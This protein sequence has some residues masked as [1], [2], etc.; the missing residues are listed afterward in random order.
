MAS[1]ITQNKSQTLYNHLQDCYSKRTTAMT[2]PGSLLEMQNCRTPLHLW[3][4]M[5][6]FTRSPGDE[7]APGF[8]EAL[9]HKTL[10]DLSFS[11]CR[12]H[13][14][15][16]S[17][18]PTLLQS[19]WFPCHLSNIRETL[20]PH[21]SLGVECSPEYLC[22][23]FR[24]L[25]QFFTQ[26]SSSQCRLPWQFVFPLF[27]LYVFSLWYLSHLKVLTFYQI[28]LLFFCLF[29]LECKLHEGRDFFVCFSHCRILHA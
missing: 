8:S 22:D 4:T 14:L 24:P 16:L 29:P 19:L 18:S 25:I 15:L 5:C 20:P 9:T 10:D 2:T 11:P 1:C 17:P 27:S 23:G 3:I 13:P 26:K 12:V 28:M 6:I 7:H 21:C